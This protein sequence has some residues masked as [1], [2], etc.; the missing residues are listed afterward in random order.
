MVELLPRL[1]YDDARNIQSFSGMGQMGGRYDLDGGCVKELCTRIRP[2]SRCVSP[3]ESVCFRCVNIA[4]NLAGPGA[5]SS[6]VGSGGRA[7]GPSAGTSTVRP[8]MNSAAVH[9]VMRATLPVLPNNKHCSRRSLIGI[10]V[11]SAKRLCSATR[12][13]SA[14]SLHCSQVG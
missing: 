7:N 10:L 8:K 5:G 9:L 2:S 14:A 1:I 11:S 3:T 6:A 12:S 13:A 4:D